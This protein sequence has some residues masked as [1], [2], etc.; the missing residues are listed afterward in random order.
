MK[1][2]ILVPVLAAVC[3]LGSCTPYAYWTDHGQPGAIK[4]TNL[5]T[6]ETRTVIVRDMTEPTKC[7]GFPRSPMGMIYDRKGDRL[8]YREGEGHAIFAVD[9]A[10]GNSLEWRVCVDGGRSIPEDFCLSPDGK[11][12]YLAVRHLPSQRWG[13]WSAATA[14]PGERQCLIEPGAETLTA[15]AAAPD[16]KSL[17]LTVG[18][19]VK[20]PR[21]FVR[22][23]LETGK[24]TPLTAALNETAGLRDFLVSP[25]GKRLYWTLNHTDNRLDG[26]WTLPADGSAAP[27]MLPLPA[28]AKSSGA[29]EIV[30]QRHFFGPDRIV[31]TDMTTGRI[32]SADL[33]GGDYRVEADPKASGEVTY[34]TALEVIRKRPGGPGS[35]AAFTKCGCGQ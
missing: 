14:T 30:Y 7:K 15:V 2:P 11:R 23:D 26:I 21:A 4:A 12:I 5:R 10:T 31:W 17:Y 32:K 20:G 9:R 34:L 6:Q 16:G 3:C 25:D 1:T 18:K 19:D 28:E 29:W 8:L 33:E 22:H 24:R 35:T 13:L 27:A